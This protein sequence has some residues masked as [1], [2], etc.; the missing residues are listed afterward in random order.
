[1]LQARRNTL[2]F[3]RDF[4]CQYQRR[5]ETV[6]PETGHAAAAGHAE[7]VHHGHH[8]APADE[9]FGSGF[10]IGLAAIPLSVAFYQFSKSPDSADPRSFITKWIGQYS[11]MKESWQ[12]RNTLHTLAVENAAF[13]R[14]LFQS[15]PADRGV[16]LRFPEMFNS[17]SPYNV[18]AGH[19]ADLREVI[20]HYEKQ[21]F[22]LQRR[23]LDK[24]EERKKQSQRS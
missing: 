7:P 1:M 8:P 9:S 10:Y 16:V 14:N 6:K 19:Q 4:R 24:M 13:D 20:G 2:R 23:Q 11:N 5:Y 15:E 17:G 21:N 3:A 12:E 18:P 22:E